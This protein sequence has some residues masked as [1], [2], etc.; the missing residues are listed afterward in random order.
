MNDRNDPRGVTTLL[1]N[2]NTQELLEP[3]LRAL[4]AAL[5]RVG[6]GPIIVVDNA[7]RDGSADYLRTHAPDVELLISESNV[8]F[9]RANNLALPKVV[10][11]YLLLLNTDA[12]VA[13]DTLDKTLAYMEQHPRCGVLGVRLIGRDG[14][15]QPSCRYFPT[16]WNMF[17]GRT[18]LSSWLPGKLV[19]DMQWGHDQVRVCDWVPGCYYLLRMDAVHEAGLFDPRFFLYYEEVDHCRAVKDKG[20]QVMFYPHTEVVH[21]GGESAAKDHEITRQGRQVP[22]LQLE[23]SLLYVRKRYGLVGLLGHLALETAGSA[24]IALKGLVRRRGL[25]DARHEG[26]RQSIVWQLVRATGWGLRPTR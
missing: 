17:L 11:K 5:S 22:A 2:Y 4:R 14:S 13:E 9:G 8:G 24:Y 19:D 21:L 23:S 15:L 10:S 6:G 26:K 3:C 16:P 12:F 20:W 1:V 18:G 25:D 7:S